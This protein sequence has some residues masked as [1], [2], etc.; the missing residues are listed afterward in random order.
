[1]QLRFPKEDRCQEELQLCNKIFRFFCTAIL[2][3]SQPRAPLS[4]PCPFQRLSSRA[5]GL[6]SKVPCDPELLLDC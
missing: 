3:T 6:L 2:P 1:M 5:H 4:C